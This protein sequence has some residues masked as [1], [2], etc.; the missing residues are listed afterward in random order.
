MK[1]FYDYEQQIA[2]LRDSDGLIIDDEETAKDYLRLE[3]YYNVINGYA[4]IFKKKNG[5]FIKGTTFDNIRNLYEFDKSLRSIVY[6]YT[7]SIEC[8]IKALIAHEFS[9][10]HG[11]DEKVR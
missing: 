11:V 9:R 5:K 8:H 7:S 2:K 6:K 1:E 3:G 4:A 10:N